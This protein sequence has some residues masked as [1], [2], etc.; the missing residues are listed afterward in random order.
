MA[1]AQATREPTTEKPH[2]VPSLVQA[3][4]PPTIEVIVRVPREETLPGQILIVG[5][6]ITPRI[7]DQ[8]KQH[9][10]DD[11]IVMMNGTS[12]K[13]DEEIDIS[14]KVRVHTVNGRNGTMPE[15]FLGVQILGFMETIGKDFAANK[16]QLPIPE[17]ITI[18]G[19]IEII[20][21]KGEIVV[22]ERQQRLL[23]ALAQSD[24]GKVRLDIRKY[25]HPL[26]RA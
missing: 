6:Y 3:E 14:G 21:E 9:G 16:E 22:D 1:N 10:G 5:T 23:S 11:I 7:D 8:G 20:H 19:L 18:L 4:R 15:E 13:V 25:F 26:P 12:R 17:G 2:L 24:I